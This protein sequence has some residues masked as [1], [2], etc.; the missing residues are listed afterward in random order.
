MQMLGR[1]RLLLQ[2]V[3]AGNVEL[4]VADRTSNGS[5]I[6]QRNCH[7]NKMQVSCKFAQNIRTC[8]LLQES[9]CTRNCNKISCFIVIW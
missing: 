3:T 2:F 6:L 8:V 7:Q 5:Q 4:Q 1:R 9:A